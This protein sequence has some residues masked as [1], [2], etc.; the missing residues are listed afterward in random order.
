MMRVLGGTARG[1]VLRTGPKS[2]HLRPI[3][4][5]V[6][7]SLFDII[8][9]R[10]QGAR[11][12]DI[13][14]GTGS[15]GIEALSQGAARAVFLEKDRRSGSVLRENLALLHMEDR[16]TAYS[17]DASGNLSGLPKPF[18]IIFMGPPYVDD[19]KKPLA[20]VTPTLEQIRAYGLLAPNGVVIAQ[21]HK[22][23]TVAATD[24]WELTRQERYGDTMLSFLRART[25]AQ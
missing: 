16:G 22:K 13:F 12:L 20:L 3:L 14:A 10:L 25:D 19:E 15:V 23:E 6:K 5:R 9:P 17:I 18:D 24:A 8:R 4:A 7:K 21:H 1:R 2:P 11:F